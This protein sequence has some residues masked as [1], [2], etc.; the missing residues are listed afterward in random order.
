MN[1]YRKLL[2]NK[3]NNLIFQAS[4][5]DRFL[6]LIKDI[7]FNIEYYAIV[8]DECDLGRIESLYDFY[9]EKM[10]FINEQIESLTNEL[11][12]SAE[13]DTSNNC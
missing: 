4:I 8:I 2:D 5:I 10:D 11:A 13:F 1:D 6:N 3:I 7:Y 12:D 9:M